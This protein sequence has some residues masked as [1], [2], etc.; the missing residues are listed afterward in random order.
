MPRGAESAAVLPAHLTGAVTILAIE[1]S[2]DETSAAVSVDGVLRANIVSSQLFHHRYGGI[3][4]ELASRA[5]LRS[6]VPIVREALDTA[7]IGIEQVTHVA[8]T[9]GPGLIGSLL[10]GLNFGKAFALSRGLPFIPVNHIE[11]HM[12][13]AFLEEP[14]PAFPYLCLVVSGGHTQLMLARAVDD[15]EI[16]GATIDDAAGEA[17]DK[18]G[19]MLGLGFPGGP[20]IDRRASR[21]D[22]T[23][24]TLPR[25]L[26]DSGDWRFSFSGLKTAVLYQ[27]RREAPEALAQGVPP[28][29]EYLN[30]LCAAFQAAV[31]DVLVEKTLRAAAAWKLR[32]IV[33]AG[34][35]ST[36]SELRRRMRTRGEA[37]G[38]RVFLPAPAYTTDNA[39]MVAQC[40]WMLLAR[41]HTGTLHAPAY[42]RTQHGSADAAT[43]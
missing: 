35:V 39:A 9:Q 29:E 3:V 1:S 14:H 25:P 13:A 6:I 12:I 32:D 20:E 38:L 41:G 5:H 23:R 31:V 15:H 8:A 33:L 11:A 27:L 34:G 42:S 10:V 16:L 22:A 7:G 24:I 18:V 30:D 19:K 21:G 26:L 40:A 43:A 36:N 2:C 37:A 28:P 17:Y 4:P